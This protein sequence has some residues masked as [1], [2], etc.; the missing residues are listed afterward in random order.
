MLL[1]LGGY[2]ILDDALVKPTRGRLAALAAISGALLL[3]HYWA[4][5]LLATLGALLLLR[6]WRVPD[7]RPTT[8]KA[9]VAIALGAVLFLPWLGGFLYQ[10]SHTGTPWGAPYRP[11]ELIQTT[12]NDLGGGLFSE[13]FL[14]GSVVFVLLFVRSSPCGRPAPR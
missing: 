7:E 10:S 4:F 11:T 9:I 8:L 5:Y 3:T 1:V 2:L 14:S 13:A 6:W 12:L